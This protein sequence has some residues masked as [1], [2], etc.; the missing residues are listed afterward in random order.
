MRAER[1]RSSF[2]KPMTRFLSLALCTYLP[3][4]A[5]AAGF[6]DCPQF[7]AFKPPT[8]QYRQ[9]HELCFS[10]FAVLYSGET[11]TPIYVFQRLNATML[12]EG[13]NL[14]RSNRFYPEARLPFQDRAQVE[15]YKRSG[16]SRGHMAPAGDMSTSD[17]KA[18]SFSLANVVPQDPI[19]NGGAWSKIEQDTRR[20]I[21]RARGDVYVITGP[22][23]GNP[24]QIIGPGKVRVPESMYKLVY[25][26]SSGRSWVHWQANSAE[27]SVRSPISV[28]DF[29]AQS[30]LLV[31]VR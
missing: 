6:A 22:L 11:K 19:H 14:P 23:F 8:S 21:R 1:I 28:A 9:L 29:E 25:D 4:A 30:G 26:S 17:G 12:E 7:F 31:F 15:D 13:Q 2:S 10:E 27:A 24:Y 18:Q 5:L 16:W 20:Y 3:A